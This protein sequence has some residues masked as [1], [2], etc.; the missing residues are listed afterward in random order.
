ML[1]SVNHV[2]LQSCHCSF[3]DVPSCTHDLHFVLK[4][5]LKLIDSAGVRNCA[6]SSDGHE[7]TL[8]S[9]LEGNLNILPLVIHAGA[10]FEDR[11]LG[12]DQVRSCK[13]TITSVNT[14]LNM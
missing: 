12:R 5:L 8:A 10:A 9:N 3:R 7:L 2:P 6:C 11:I 4:K 13:Q 1:R 14:V